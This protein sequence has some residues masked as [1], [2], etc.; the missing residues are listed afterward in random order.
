MPTRR[1]PRSRSPW[2]K[3]NP[4]ARGHT[5]MFAVSHF[6]PGWSGPLKTERCQILPRPLAP[7]PLFFGPAAPARVHRPDRP[8]EAE[9]QTGPIVLMEL[10]ATSNPIP[11]I[12]MGFTTGSPGC[13][14][15]DT[16][17]VRGS[18]AQPR[19]NKHISSPWVVLRHLSGIS[20]QLMADILQH[21][22][23]QR[24]EDPNVV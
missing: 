24:G 15:F 21:S 8:A 1:P 5:S 14:S 22:S 3:Q 10:M 16:H 7:V 6:P 23:H 9:L 13:T 20:R 19:M 17:A 2:F 12:L 11:E 18:W 4:H